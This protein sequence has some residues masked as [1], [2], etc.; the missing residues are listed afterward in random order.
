VSPRMPDDRP[1]PVRQLFRWALAAALPRRLFLTSGQQRSRQVCLTF[2]DGPHPEHTPPLLDALAALNAKATFF[3]IGREAELYPEIVR[4]IAADGHSIGNHTWTH[5]YP[6]SLSGEEF[7]GEVQQTRTLLSF[8]AGADSSLV[9]PPHG[10]ITAGQMLRLWR[11]RETIVLWNHDP[12]DFACQSA[13][14][15]SAAFRERPVEGG[16]VVLLHDNHP[17][18][19]AVVRDVVVDARARGLSFAT[20]DSLLMSSDRVAIRRTSA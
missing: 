3:L 5:R 8:I 2:D 20:I 7:A 15:L 9:R 6:H 14:V 4:R 10:K 19:H 11:R 1:N 16:D 12:K 17:H 13:E 18:A